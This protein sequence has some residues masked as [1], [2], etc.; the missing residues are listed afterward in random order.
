VSDS[1]R[2][3]FEVACA[4][5]QAFVIWTERMGTWWP[6]DHTIS[7]APAAVVL[8][9]W[10]GGRIYER[11]VQ[12]KELDWG[13]VTDWR[14]PEQLS[15]RWHLGSG[16][17]AA[18]D[19]QVRFISLHDAR[20]RVEIEQSGWERL[21]EAGSEIQRRNRVGWESLVRH[22]RAAVEKGA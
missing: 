6:A 19:V 9:G 11:T 5:E 7:G 12:G 4:I 8:E 21:G 2:I 1:L 22:V 10:V 3:D 20:T 17:E 15:Y 16:P 18:T 13:L 14:P